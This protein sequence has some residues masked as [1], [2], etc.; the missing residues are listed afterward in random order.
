MCSFLGWYHKSYWESVE[1]IENEECWP[2]LCGFTEVGLEDCSFF[3]FNS[4]LGEKGKNKNYDLL[5]FFFA[6][7]SGGNLIC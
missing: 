3:F 7:I 5:F 4:F 2:G 6:K 1:N